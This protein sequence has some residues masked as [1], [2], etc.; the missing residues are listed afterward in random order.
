MIPV[1]TSVLDDIVDEFNELPR[2]YKA[3]S[4]M[5][6]N[7]WMFDVRYAQTSYN[8]SSKLT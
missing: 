4:G 8:P 7:H 5:V 3:P 1:D 6:D 2:T